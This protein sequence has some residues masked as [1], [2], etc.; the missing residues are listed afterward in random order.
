MKS[1]KYAGGCP[2]VGHVLAASGVFGIA[3]AAMG[4]ARHPGRVLALT[5]GF[6][7]QNGAT[8]IEAPEASA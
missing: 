3:H 2:S 7:G 5:V 1:F 4:L 6:G 8:L